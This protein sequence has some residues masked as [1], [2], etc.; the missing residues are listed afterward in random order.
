MVTETLDES[1]S[2]PDYNIQHSHVLN[3]RDIIRFPI[4]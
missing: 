1:A 4:H 3:F 2:R